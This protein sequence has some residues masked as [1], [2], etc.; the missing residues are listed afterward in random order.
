MNTTATNTTVDCETQ[1]RD[2]LSREILFSDEFPYRDDSSLLDE[3]IVDSMGVVQ[4]V[5]FVQSNFGIRVEPN[6]ITK[7][8][9]DSIRKLAAYIRG[10]SER[11]GI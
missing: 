9:F 5:M 1:I 2:F 6:E 8:N 7:S 3:G 11:S 10:K 4:V